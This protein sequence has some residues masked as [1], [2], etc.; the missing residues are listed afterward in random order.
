VNAS[1][2]AITQTWFASLRH[3]LDDSSEATILD[4]TPTVL[5]TFGIPLSAVV[6]PYRGRALVP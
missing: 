6:P 1:D 5:E 2:P 3:N 4:V